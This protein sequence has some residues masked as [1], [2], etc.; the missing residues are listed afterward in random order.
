VLTAHERLRSQ[1]RYPISTLSCP[2]TQKPAC[3]LARQTNLAKLL[4]NLR[5][6]LT[7]PPKPEFAPHDSSQLADPTPTQAIR[8]PL[9]S[10]R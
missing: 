3:V 7:L 1:T 4:R 5:S 10:H 9:K 6:G 2:P 8:R